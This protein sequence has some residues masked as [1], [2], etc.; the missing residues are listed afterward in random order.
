MKKENINLPVQMDATRLEA[1]V[2][3]VGRGCLAGPVVTAAVIL[4]HDLQIRG[5]RDSKQLSAAKREALADEI[6]AK[7]I[8]YHIGTAS[9][10]EIDRLN[11]LQATYLAMHRA[12]E[13]LSIRPDFL[14]I[15]GNRFVSHLDIPYRT[16][17]KGDDTYLCIAAASVLAKVHRDHI[18]TALH[19]EYPEYDWVHNVGYGTPK[20]L[21]GIHEHGI[22]PHHRRSF[23]PCQPTLFDDV[24]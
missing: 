22:T 3:E 16:I 12:I 8:A 19:D 7:A 24:K 6:K 21:V 5:L 1:G 4:P 23:A 14:L 11:I 10:D 2:D 9:V 18:M 13:G 15:D 17:V 20:H